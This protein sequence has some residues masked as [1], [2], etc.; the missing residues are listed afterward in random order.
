M[1]FGLN[2]ESIIKLPLSRKIIILAVINVFIIGAIYWFLISPKREEIGNLR[3]DFDDLSQKLDENRRV[4]ADI[5]RYRQ[6]KEDMER[7]LLDVVAKLPNEKEIPD[8]IDGISEAGEKA[9]LKILLFKPGREVPKGFY[10]D[11]PVTMSVDGRF[12]SFYDFS[13]KVAGLPRIVNLSGMDIKS[14]GHKNRIPVLKADF[15][16]TTFRF[17]PTEGKGAV[18]GEGGEGAPE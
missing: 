18:G 1:A 13:N 6:E 8:L 9:G 5:P 17:L 15:V 3:A 11:I 14:Q 7:K 4:A 12:E 2:I 16:A 10:A